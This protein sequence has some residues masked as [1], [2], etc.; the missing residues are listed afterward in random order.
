MNH[1]QNNVLHYL[2]QKDYFLVEHEYGRE[3]VFVIAPDYVTAR[4]L[5]INWIKQPRDNEL[6][7]WD[8]DKKMYQSDLDQLFNLPL[9]PST[10]TLSFREIVDYGAIF[11]SLHHFHIH[12]MKLSSHNDNPL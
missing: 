7:F 5:I 11:V 8:P 1:L 10:L 12:K 9:T 2:E 3:Q 4:K 6:Q